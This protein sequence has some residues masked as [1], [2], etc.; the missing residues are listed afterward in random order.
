VDV[1]PV[2]ERPRNFAAVLPDLLGGAPAGPVGI[3]VMAAGT[4]VHSRHQHEA[5]G[6]HGRDRGPGDGDAPVFQGLPQNL[7]GVLPE[8]R[9]L[10]EKQDAIVGK[11]DLAGA[12]H[13]PPAD[14]SYIGDGVMRGAEGPRVY[15][16]IFPGQE[17][18]HG[19]DLGGLDGLIEGQ[20][21][22]NRRDYLNLMMVIFLH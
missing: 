8:L 6:E 16:R 18:R 2:E 12:G 11:A 13:L 4:G 1:D 17:S 5:G 21:G 22:Q 20:V 10:V 14:K 19:E 15:E 3:C 9:Q 7:Q